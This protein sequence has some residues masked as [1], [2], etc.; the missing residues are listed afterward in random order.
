MRTYFT[1]AILGLA[2]PSAFAGLL[3]LDPG[4]AL[5]QMSSSSNDGYDNGRGMWFQANS[6]FTLNGAGFYNGYLG[7]E[8]FTETLYAADST[9]S[10]LHGSV[11]GSFNVTGPTPGSLYNNGLFASPV[12]I[13][14]GNYYYLEVT[15]TSAF[16]KNY[17]YNWNGN[18]SV[19]LGIVTILDGGQGPDSGALSNTVAPGL[20]LDVEPV[21]EP[22]TMAVL[23]I[24]ALGLIRR[25]R[26]KAI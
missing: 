26:N 10:A 25:R 8:T 22:A 9:G 24:G 17:F 11:L 4:V 5:T 7:S 12:S 20:L 13:V 3:P 14:A 23:G 15:S 19:N 6:S 21:P 2:V 1:L 16:D 18:P